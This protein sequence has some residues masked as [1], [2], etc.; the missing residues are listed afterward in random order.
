MPLFDPVSEVARK[1]QIQIRKK[2]EKKKKIS[3]LKEKEIKTKEKIKI[4]RCS[5]CDQEKSYQELKIY[6][7]ICK[8]CH[9]IAAAAILRRRPRRPPSPFG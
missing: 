7:G 2:E 4:Y 9:Y 1:Y 3:G 6:N 5:R 8:R